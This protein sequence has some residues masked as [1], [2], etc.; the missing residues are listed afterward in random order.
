MP[1]QGCAD[2]LMYCCLFCR[3][4][5]SET[6]RGPFWHQED[7]KL[8]MACFSMRLFAPCA[9]MLSK[10]GFLSAVALCAPSD[11]SHPG[12]SWL[13]Q[14]DHHAYFRQESCDLR[15]PKSSYPLSSLNIFA[16]TLPSAFSVKV[17]VYLLSPFVLDGV[18]VLWRLSSF[19]FVCLFAFLSPFSFPLGAHGLCSFGVFLL[20]S[21][22]HPFCFCC[23]CAVHLVACLRLVS[24][25]FI[26]VL[27]SIGG[28]GH[29]ACSPQNVSV[30]SMFPEVLP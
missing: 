16:S 12:G 30:I 29:A 11:C 5:T 2:M 20:A 21:P 8:R 28:F 3:K 17:C 7:A 1:S 4:I 14:L 26:F 6:K 15:N 9:W 25:V 23:R 24:L 27:L 13:E 10:S 19:L 22:F 18:S